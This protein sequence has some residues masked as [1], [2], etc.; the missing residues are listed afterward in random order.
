MEA[1]GF[2]LNNDGVF[3]IPENGPVRME[4]PSLLIP[5]HPDDGSEVT[6]NLRSDDSFVEDDG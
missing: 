5:R 6:V 3:E 1:Q 2:I 4:I